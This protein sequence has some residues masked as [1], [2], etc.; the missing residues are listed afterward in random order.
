MGGCHGSLCAKDGKVVHKYQYS[1]PLLVFL[2]NT[3]QTQHYN[4]NNNQSL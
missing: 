2:T 3:L 1:P 4:P